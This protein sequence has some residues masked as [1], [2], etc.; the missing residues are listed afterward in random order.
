MEKRAGKRKLAG[1]RAE[2]FITHPAQMDREKAV[3]KE[4]E[5]LGDRIRKARETHNLTIQE[6]SNR[7]GIDTDI[8]K[9]IEANK[10]TPPLGELVKLGKALETRMS[11]LIS[12]GTDKPM[13][14]V[15]ADQR[16]EVSRHAGRSSVRYGYFY[17]SLAPE[18]ANRLME[19]FMITLTLSDEVKPSIHDGQEFLFVLE[20]QMMAQVGDQKEYLK[21]GDAVYYDSSEPH[22]VKCVGGKEAK[23][24][25][26]L[27]TGR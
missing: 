14:I 15:R 18:K 2:D 7:T 21:P 25:A 16:K 22:F 1:G 13:T 27:Y 17:E 3:L 24:L 23:I 10:M 5:S 19:P 9:R 20:G 6:L 12:P 26:V 4:K 8:L 11:F